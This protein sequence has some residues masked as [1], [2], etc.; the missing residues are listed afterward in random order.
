MKGLSNEQGA[1][2]LVLLLIMIPLFVAGILLVSEHP[3]WV[4]GADPDLGRTVA[5][6]A[7]FA[8][9]SVDARSQA[10]GDPRIDPERAHKSF[11]RFLSRNV[12]LS[13][14][15]GYILVVHNGPNGFGFPEARE[16][17]W[18]GGTVSVADRPF[19]DGAFGVGDFYIAPGAGERSVTL[20]GPGC[21]AVVR[22]KVTPTVGEPAP[23]IR[24][25]AATLKKTSGG[26][27][28]P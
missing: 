12:R 15:D 16:Y 24:W 25:A 10:H 7:R 8:A 11:Q 28:E 27:F 18:E 9:M 5:E 14:L 26:L 1:A 23:V 17:V 4:H 3:R 20:D 22:G 13:R 21:V 6:A 19:S 2:N